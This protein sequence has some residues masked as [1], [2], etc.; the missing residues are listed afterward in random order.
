MKKR[1]ISK[2]WKELIDDCN[3]IHLEYAAIREELISLGRE[4]EGDFQ[5]LEK[6]LQ[7]LKEFEDSGDDEGS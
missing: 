5:A 7:E 6:L 3:R 4:I 1:G 2:E